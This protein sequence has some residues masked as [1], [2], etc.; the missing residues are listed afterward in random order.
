M[1]CDEGEARL[2]WWQG[3]GAQA[4]GAQPGSLGCAN[5]LENGAG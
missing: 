1:M 3:R 5:D 4:A 2:P